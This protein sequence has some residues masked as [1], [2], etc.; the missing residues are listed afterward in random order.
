MKIVAV[1]LVVLALAASASSESCSPSSGFDFFTFDLQYPPSFGCGYSYWTLHGLWPSNT[2]GD[3]PCYCNKDPWDLDKLSSIEDDL[4]KYWASLIA[5]CDNNEAR[6]LN[7]LEGGH[8]SVD[9]WQHEWEKHGVCA[10]ILTE[11]DTILKFFTKAL[12][13]REQFDVEAGLSNA[14]VSPGDSPSYSDAMYA[15][16][17]VF[18]TEVIMSCKYTNGNQ[19]ISTVAACLDKNF[20]SIDC[21]PRS[22]SCDSSK[23]VYFAKPQ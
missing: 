7:P 21:A 18:G 22:N 8:S 14:G 16:K 23:P 12:A 9:F 10:E 5:V 20:Q 17:Q 3:D 1:A 15:F 4:N 13:L 6:A 2:T 11:T 19:E